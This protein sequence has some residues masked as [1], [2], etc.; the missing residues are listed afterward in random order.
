MTRLGSI[1]LLVALLLGLLWAGQRWMIYFPMG[2]VAH[3]SASGV[4]AEAVTFEADDGLTLGGW[5]VPARTA[6]PRFTVIVFNGNAGHRGMRAPLAAALA[7]RGIA[8]FLF[9]Y[10]GFGDNPGSP[11]EAG[12]SRDARAARRY[13]ATRRDVD[14]TRL[15]YFGESL[16]SAV[17]V[18]LAAEEAPLALVLRSPFTSLADIGRYH[19]PYLPVRW[20]LRDRYPAID[21]VPRVTSP[22]LVIAGDRDGIVPI[23]HS[24]RLYAA[25]RSPKRFVTIGGANHNDVELLAGERLISEAVRFISA[26]APPP[27]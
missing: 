2:G 17:A 20:L 9:D 10:R 19:Y 24:L 1:V 4:T 15:V 13:V 23:A 14:S 3:P 12:L 11:T 25:I 16:G 21:L 5:F 27:S 22:V 7:E 8:T 6:P 18:R 26:L